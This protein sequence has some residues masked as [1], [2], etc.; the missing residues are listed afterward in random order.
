MA[1]RDPHFPFDR[2]TYRDGQLLSALDLNEERLRAA[3]LRWLHS[4]AVHGDWGIL[5]GLEIDLLSSGAIRVRAGVAQ[6]CYG[7]ELLLARAVV[8]PLPHGQ[9][10]QESVLTLSYR[11][12]GDYPARPGAPI[13]I[14][15]GWSDQGERP[16][17]NWRRIEDVHF[18]PEVPLA[19]V[20]MMDGR[21]QSP[22]DTRVR[23]Y[24]RRKVMPHVVGG[25]TDEGRTGW[26]RWPAD[27]TALGIE[28]IVDTTDAGFV[29]D[30]M[31]FAALDADLTPRPER[32]SPLF[33]S[34][35]WNDVSFF[36]EAFV[37]VTEATPSKFIFRVVDLQRL[38]IGGDGDADAT[39]GGDFALDAESRGW[40]VRWL[41]VE[42][43]AGCP[44]PDILTF[45]LSGY[46]LSPQL[47]T[48]VN[49]G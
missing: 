11:E 16:R 15:G 10:E 38:G 40:T 1:D 5:F 31:Y 18:G 32:P 46:L 22:P 8:P 9:Q 26:R 35:P 43:V 2:V 7:R 4:A 27:G 12:D 44:P 30:A 13:C 34:V 42:P 24:A 21:V 47:L 3:A 6:D 25:K 19:R 33:P 36:A 29:R 48:L 28:T 17:F 49:R 41:G 23:R 45:T 20:R 39:T 37:F 14:G